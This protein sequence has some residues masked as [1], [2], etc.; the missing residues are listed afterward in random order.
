MQRRVGRDLTRGS[1]QV[2]SKSHIRLPGGIR[3]EIL[4]LCKAGKWLKSK[5]Q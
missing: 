5:H 4:S 1:G 2:K 3:V